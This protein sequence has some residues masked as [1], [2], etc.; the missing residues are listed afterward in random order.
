MY[1]AILGDIAGSRFEFSRPQNFDW[2]TTDFFGGMS[3]YTDDTVLTVAT[4]YA[5]LTG[6][7]YAKAYSLF[8]KRYSRVGYGTMFKNWLN[9]SSQKGYNSFGNGAAMRVS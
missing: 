5:V 3:T 1:G 6:T 7:P 9:S 4:K 8:G 2:K